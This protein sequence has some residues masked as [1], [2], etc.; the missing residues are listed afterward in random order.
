MAH[1]GVHN[2]GSIT[3]VDY[4]SYIEDSLPS[5][6]SARVLMPAYVSHCCGPQSSHK[7][8]CALARNRGRRLRMA[9]GRLQS[10]VA[11]SGTLQPG[12]SPRFSDKEWADSA[13]VRRGDR[14]P[15]APSWSHFCFAGV[16]DL[17]ARRSGVSSLLFSLKGRCLDSRRIGIKFEIDRHLGE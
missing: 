6:Y 8:L 9:I 10:A 16:S 13:E 1:V 4:C 11:F 2:P 5:R 17:P 15:I 14:T 12:S 7:R 3:C